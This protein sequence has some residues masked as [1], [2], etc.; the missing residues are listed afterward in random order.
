MKIQ[1]TYQE[2]MTLEEVARQSRP[3]SESPNN[4]IIRKMFKQKY[5]VNQEEFLAQNTADVSG[6]HETRRGGTTKPAAERI[7]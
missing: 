1:Q 7:S 2:N 6:E 4:S 5:F 3:L